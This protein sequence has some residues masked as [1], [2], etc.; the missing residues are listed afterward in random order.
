[1]ASPSG[2]GSASSRSTAI[3]TAVVVDEADHVARDA[4]LADLDEPLV[5][6]LGQRL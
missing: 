5:L 4:P 1:M 2:F 6:P 3:P